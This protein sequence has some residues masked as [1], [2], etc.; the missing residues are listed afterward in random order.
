MSVVLFM[1]AQQLEITTQQSETT[2]Q[3]LETTTQQPETTIE[4][5]T[6]TIPEPTPAN[7]PLIEAEEQALDI[8][9]E[10]LH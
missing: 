9:S 10:N 8:V 4:Q 7:L 3:Q 1:Y 5:L 2:S 6:T